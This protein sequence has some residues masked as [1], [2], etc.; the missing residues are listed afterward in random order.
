MFASSTMV[1]QATDMRPR[2]RQI[3]NAP[4]QLSER[5]SRLIHTFASGGIWPVLQDRTR[6]RVVRTE[7]TAR[8]VVQ[9]S[10]VLDCEPRIVVVEVGVHVDTLGEPGGKASAIQNRR[11]SPYRPW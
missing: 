2:T 6:A 4:R 5:T 9:A 7:T 8:A 10:G 11:C 3:S 1:V